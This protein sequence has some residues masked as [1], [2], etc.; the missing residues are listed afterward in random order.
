V[1][2]VMVIAISLSSFKRGCTG[3]PH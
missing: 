3:K 2:P 1:S